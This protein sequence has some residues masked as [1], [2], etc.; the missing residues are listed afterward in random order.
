MKL[1]VMHCQ[2]GHKWL[3][4]GRTL[5]DAQSGWD[6]LVADGKAEPATSRWLDGDRKLAAYLRSIGQA[7]A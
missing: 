1:I 4:R 3:V 2:S 7:D 5:A 6:R